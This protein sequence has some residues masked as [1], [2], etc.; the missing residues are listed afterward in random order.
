[1]RSPRT[2]ERYRPTIH[3]G[4]LG[5]KG[6][7]KSRLA[8]ALARTCA[9]LY[10]QPPPP[11]YEAL[12]R[13]G[14]PSSATYTA[15]CR[16]E[17]LSLETPQHHLNLLAYP[18]DVSCA[19]EYF[20]SCSTLDAALLV[21]DAT[22]GPTPETR[23]DAHALWAMQVRRVFVWLSAVDAVDD[24]EIVD[25][26]EAET[27]EL[28]ASA[29]VPSSGAIRAIGWEPHGARGSFEQ[30]SDLLG[31]IERSVAAYRGGGLP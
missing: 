7:G 22:H 13:G 30:L 14:C 9:E 8:V 21:V 6:H 10:P 19:P 28:L 11:T 23:H 3:L 25:A 16:I 15:S 1:M 17:R 31:R 24:P 27:L 26:V 20:S 29:G 4:I 5:G 2:T 12:T 18:G